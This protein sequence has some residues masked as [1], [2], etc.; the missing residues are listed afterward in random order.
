M[1]DQFELFLTAVAFFTRMPVPAGLA[2]SEQRLNHSARYFPW[3]GWLV[4]AV[5][6]AVFGLGLLAL[7]A[8]VAVVLSMAATLRLTGAFHE[9][10]LAD[11]CD[12]LGG[13]WERDQVLRIMKDSRIGS[14]GAAALVLMLLAKALAL[15]E[16]AMIEPSLAALA[17]FVAHPLSRLASTALIER[18]EYVRDDDS[19]R[20]KPLAHRLQ[21][22]E[23]LIAAAGGLLPLATLPPSAALAATITVLAVTTWFAR[24]LR[25]RLGGYTGD[26]L[27]AAQQFAELGSYL[28]ILAACSSS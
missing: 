3:V 22:A 4:G 26:C 24:L 28:G 12:G 6:A 17:L 19:A 10:G 18:L 14:F 11:A 1:R 25:R 27:G 8:S 13:G 15:I 9:D 16:L 5:A 7:P 23:L 21:R 2:W 20:A